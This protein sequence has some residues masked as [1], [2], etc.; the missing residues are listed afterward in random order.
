MRDR[1]SFDLFEGLSA[2][3]ARDKGW[4]DSLSPEG[5]KAAAPIVI[6][7]W[8]TGTSDPAQ[9]IRLNTFV[10]PYLVG[11]CA[12]KS[13]LF[14]LLAIAATGKTRRYNWIKAPG[15]KA[16][17]HSIEVIKEY[18]E[19]STREAV[20]YV[21][22]SDDLV[23]M[24]EALGWDKDEITKLKKETEDGTRESPKA[25]AKPKKPARK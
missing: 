7:R 24:A 1:S 22:S 14:K 20:T 5:Q 19:C 8:M 17:K 9:L 21:V 10:N 2:L 3:S 12:D 13:A 6:A 4:F 18:Y 15:T 25:G 16:K 23:E 11:G